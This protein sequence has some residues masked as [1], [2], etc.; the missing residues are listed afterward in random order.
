[1]SRRT[2]RLVTYLGTCPTTGKQQHETAA[3]AKRAARLTGKGLHSYQCP[4][5]RLYHVGHMGTAT[6]EDMRARRRE[7]SEKAKALAELYSAMPTQENWNALMAAL[8]IPADR[9]PMR[10]PDP[11]ATTAVARVDRER[12]SS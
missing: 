6:R 5:C 1:M 7:P 3:R 4:D 8:N 9:S 12:K 10:G 2:E 11:T